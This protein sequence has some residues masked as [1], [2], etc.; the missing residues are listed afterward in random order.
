MTSASS[1]AIR[2]LADPT[3]HR[4]VQLLAR[5]ALCTTH[6][7]EE[8]GATQTNISNHMRV[9]RE[10]GLVT[11]EPCGRYKYYRLEPQ[12]LHAAAAAMGELAAGA[13]RV[14]AEDLRRPC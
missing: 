8:T 11:V 3:R 6:L 13:Q 4:I 2:I 7:V 5:E 14:A 9:L 1:D 10:A 12:A